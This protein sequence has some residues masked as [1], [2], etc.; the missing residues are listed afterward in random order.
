MS[1]ERFNPLAGA[2]LQRASELARC[3]VQSSAPKVEAAGA[4][5][6]SLPCDS[7]LATR[8]SIHE[9]VCGLFHWARREQQADN[10][11][12]NAARALDASPSVVRVRDKDAT[13][14]AGR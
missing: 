14:A 7:R 10:I 12:A 4:S 5:S 9:T 1:L 3:K 2:P 6:E 8:E 11:V 13:D